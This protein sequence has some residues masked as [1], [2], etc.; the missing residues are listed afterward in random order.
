MLIFNIYFIVLVFLYSLSSIAYAPAEGNITSYFG[1][2]LYK[3][4]FAG[5]PTG[6]KSPDLAGLGLVVNGDINDKGSLEIG[7]FQLNKIYFREEQGGFIAEQTALVHITMG[8]RR[9]LSQ[10]FSTSLTFFSAYSLGSTKIIHS[11]FSAGAEVDTSARDI[12]E[13]GFDLA[14][15]SELYSTSNYAIVLDARYSASVTNK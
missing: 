9:W 13:Y 10:Y 3:T 7:L 2:Y 14:L 12:T 4:N 8:Y 6:A 5:S 15:Q 11:D 1:P